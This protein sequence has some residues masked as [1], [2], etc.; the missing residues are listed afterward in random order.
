MDYFIKNILLGLE[1]EN[2]TVSEIFEITKKSGDEKT[3]S[4]LN[5]VSPENFQ[6]I[7]DISFDMNFCKDKT[8]NSILA[9]VF[10]V[11]GK[12]SAFEQIKEINFCR[13][14]ILAYYEKKEQLLL[15][16]AKLSKYSGI[17]AGIFAAIILL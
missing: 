5:S 13:S 11:F 4:F 7:A 8:V 14:K 2:M 3:N 12:Y 15:Q 17:L 1:S 6:D 10:F 16:K 9:E